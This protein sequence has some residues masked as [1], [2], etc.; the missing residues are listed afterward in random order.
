MGREHATVRTLLLIGNKELLHQVH[1]DPSP[2]RIITLAHLLAPS[3]EGREVIRQDGLPLVLR[4]NLDEVAAVPEGVFQMLL[5]VRTGK[6]TAGERGVATHKGDAED[7][8]D[9]DEDGC[10]G[11]G[12]TSGEDSD[13]DGCVG[14]GS[15]SGA[16]TDGGED[17]DSGRYAGR[18]LRKFERVRSTSRS[19][20]HS[21]AFRSPYL[22]SEEIRGRGGGEIKS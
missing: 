19:C 1:V 8:E 22:L 18:D 7:G 16:E 12:S 17:E 3:G 21:F 13:E 4:R 15:T 9:S 11:D 14:V 2:T 20:R 6:G 10:V 5:A